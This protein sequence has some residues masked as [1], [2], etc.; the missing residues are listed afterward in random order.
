MCRYGEAGWLEDLPP[1]ATQRRQHACAGFSRQDGARVLLV[2]G[3]RQSATSSQFLTSVELLVVGHSAWRS[4]TPLPVGIKAAAAATIDNTV[5]ITGR[6]SHVFWMT[7]SAN[8][9]T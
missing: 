1:L 9:K 7:T 4:A 5:F 2:A 3:G 8:L 6:S